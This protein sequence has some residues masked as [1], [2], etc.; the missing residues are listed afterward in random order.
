M[1]YHAWLVIQICYSGFPRE[2]WSARLVRRYKSTL[3]FVWQSSSQ[4]LTRGQK[5]QSRRGREIC[6]KVLHFREEKEKWI[7]F[8][9]VSRGEISVPNSSYKLFF[10]KIWSKDGRF[11]GKNTRK[12]QSFCDSVAF[13]SV[14]ETGTKSQKLRGKRYVFLKSLVFR[15]LRNWEEKEKFFSE[16]WKSRRERDLCFWI[17]AI[18][19]RTRIFS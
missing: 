3:I 5:V 2:Q 8:S 13:Y 18:E 6:K 7:F 12:I 9:Q 10:V 19:K 1:L 14:I 16:S 11:L 4:P 17:S 15:N